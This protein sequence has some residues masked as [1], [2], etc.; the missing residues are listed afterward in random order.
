MGN[1]VVSGWW[2]SSACLQLPTTDHQP[3]RTSTFNSERQV[4]AIAE[5]RHLGRRPVAYSPD[6][7]VESPRYASI[8]FTEPPRFAERVTY[9]TASDPSNTT[10]SKDKATAPAFARSS[11][12]LCVAKT[13]SKDKKPWRMP[14]LCGRI[15]GRRLV[16][17][18][19]TPS[20]VHLK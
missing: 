18:T 13:L 20:S 9:E 7:G 11:R 15:A 4:P 2:Q 14:R 1:A 6:A 3:I 8:A 5:T 17:A 10:G 19:S 12:E 16:R